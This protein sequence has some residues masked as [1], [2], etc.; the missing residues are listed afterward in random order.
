M[1]IIIIIFTLSISINNSY[2]SEVKIVDGDTINLNGDKIRFSGIDAP[3]SFY[4]GREQLCLKKKIIIRCGKLSKD[5]LIKI[6]GKNTVTCKKEKKPDKYNRILAE[7]FV[8][9]QSLS[10]ALVKNGFAFD[11]PKYS[12]KKYSKFQKYA[13]KNKLGLWDMEFKFP[14]DFRREIR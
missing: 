2:A 3:E 10:K 12:K 11:Y 13:K 7:C 14:W 5:F 9:G 1:K 6:I 8:K 4:K